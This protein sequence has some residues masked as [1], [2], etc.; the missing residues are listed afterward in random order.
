[1]MKQLLYYLVYGV[2]YLLSLL[3]MRVHYVFSDMLYLIV[4]RLVG[5]RRDLVRRH[6]ASSFSEKSSL[7]LKQVQDLIQVA[8]TVS[9]LA[10][11]SGH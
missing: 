7:A 10:L 2:W 5:Y 9:P 8:Y 6:L 4:Y 3:P 11:R 1:M